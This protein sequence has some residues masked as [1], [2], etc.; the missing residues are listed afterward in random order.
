MFLNRANDQEDCI[1]DD[2]NNHE[3]SKILMNI[4]QEINGNR[5]HQIKLGS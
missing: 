5:L 1:I 4:N 2:K 3:V